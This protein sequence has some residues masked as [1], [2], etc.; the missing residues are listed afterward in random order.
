MKLIDVENREAVL[1]YLT[2][3]SRTLP[4][5]MQIQ[6][7]NVDWRTQQRYRL[8]LVDAINE[9]DAL[10]PG[11]IPANSRDIFYTYYKGL[12][13]NHPM[14]QLLVQINYLLKIYEGSLT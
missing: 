10:C 7:K 9:I 4:F 12:Q 14:Q 5:Y 2:E 11:V 8:H 13:A 1:H 3:M 6:S